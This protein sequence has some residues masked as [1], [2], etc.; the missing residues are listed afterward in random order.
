[1][2]S[3]RQMTREDRNALITVQRIAEAVTAVV[4]ETPAGA[5]GGVLYT[6][7]M[8]HQ[9]RPVRDDDACPRRGRADRPSGRPLFTHRPTAQ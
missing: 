8:V 5:T 4:N 2:S 1:M 6:A 3:A 7:L 9:R